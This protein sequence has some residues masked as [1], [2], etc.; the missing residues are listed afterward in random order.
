MVG[1]ADYPNGQLVATEEVSR[2]TKRLPPHSNMAGIRFCEAISRTL[3]L[4]AVA[5]DSPDCLEACRKR[6]AAFCL[7]CG[8]EVF[9]R[10]ICD[11]LD[12][13]QFHDDEGTRE[14]A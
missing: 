12:L 9:S 13:F 2:R 6:F 1:L 7:Q 4:G 3:R 8:N 14:E 5:M 10:A 11:F